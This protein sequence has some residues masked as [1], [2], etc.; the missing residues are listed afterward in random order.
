MRKSSMLLTVSEAQPGLS[1]MVPYYARRTCYHL[2]YLQRRVPTA[3]IPPGMMTIK[4]L[5]FRALKQGSGTVKGYLQKLNLLSRYARE[6][7]STETAKVERFMEGLQQS[8]QYQLVVWDC[9]TFS[10]LVN[11]A[12]MLEDKRHAMDDTRKRTQRG[13]MEHHQ[14]QVIGVV[15]HTMVDGAGNHLI[16]FVETEPWGCAAHAAILT[17]RSTGRE[18]DLALRETTII[19]REAVVALYEWEAAQTAFD[20]EVECELLG[21]LEGCV[22]ADEAALAAVHRA[23]WQGTQATLQAALR[24]EGEVKEELKLLQAQVGEGIDVV[25]VAKDDMAHAR[26]IKAECAKQFLE[27]ARH[28]GGARGWRLP[29]LLPQDSALTCVFSNLRRR[30]SNFDFSHVM[31]WVLAELRN[32]FGA[33]SDGTTEVI[34][35]RCKG[36]GSDGGS[37]R[38]AT[39]EAPLRGHRRSP[40]WARTGSSIHDRVQL[41]GTEV[42]SEAAADGANGM[43]Q[44]GYVLHSKFDRA[45]MLFK[46]VFRD[47]GGRMDCYVESDSNGSNF[48]SGT[49]GSG[50]SS[51]TGSHGDAHAFTTLI[52]FVRV[53]ERTLIDVASDTEHL[54]GSKDDEVDDDEEKM[55]ETNVEHGDKVDSSSSDEVSPEACSKA[56]QDPRV[57]AAGAKRPRVKKSTVSAMPTHSSKRGWSEHE[58]ACGLGNHN[59]AMDEEVQDTRLSLAAEKSKTKCLE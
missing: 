50:S 19:E 56:R 4:K 38:V 11:K 5:E 43:A 46:K 18:V 24:S 36:G 55:E 21:I 10:D 7:V 29:Q 23:E 28:A 6:D 32:P 27:L 41:V 33:S 51:S 58:T 13:H 30:D 42:V 44:E 14:W 2:G 31:E 52:I 3:H 47:I 26:H 12:L 45:A 15:C 9:R 40:S 39:D 1:G 49:D 34:P 59:D 8:L 35:C 16:G 57:R 25:Q 20:H 37:R 54:E 17:S 53:V 48:A 22:L